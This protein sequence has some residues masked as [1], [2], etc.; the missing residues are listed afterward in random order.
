[1]KTRREIDAAYAQRE[2][3]FCDLLADGRD[4]VE[5]RALMNLTNGAAQGMLCRIRRKLGPQAI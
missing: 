1:M 2:A 5:I 3:R 4:M